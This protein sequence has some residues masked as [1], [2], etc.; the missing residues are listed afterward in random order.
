MLLC[1]TNF[2][3]IRTNIC[4]IKIRLLSFV[5]I[6]HF[7]PSCF[8]KLRVCI[9]KETISP[10][11]NNHTIV[12]S[13][14]TTALRLTSEKHND[15]LMSLSITFCFLPFSV[16][17]RCRFRKKA[18]SLTLKYREILQ[19]STILTL[20]RYQCVYMALSFIQKTEEKPGGK[21][22]PRGG[23]RTP[24]TLVWRSNHLSYPGGPVFTTTYR[25]YTSP[26]FLF[27]ADPAL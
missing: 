9:N 25:L 18:L 3:W 10:Q 22:A 14:E 19:M 7:G 13:L 5:K 11:N 16:I 26:P 17:F 15:G 2:D 12:F 4:P 24:G 27:R 23:A 6:H 8:A 21:I 20:R 1:N